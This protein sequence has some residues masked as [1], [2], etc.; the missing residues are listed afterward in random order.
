MNLTDGASFLAGVSPH[1]IRQMASPTS[2]GFSRRR[3]ERSS[4]C[5]DRAQGALW[6]HETRHLGREANH[7]KFCRYSRHSWHHPLYLH[8]HGG[9][10]RVRADSYARSRCCANSRWSGFPEPYLQ[11]L[12]RGEASPRNQRS[13]CAD[14]AWHEACN[15][16]SRI[17]R[18]DHRN[19]VGLFSLGATSGSRFGEFARTFHQDEVAAS[20][21]QYLMRGYANVADFPSLS[22]SV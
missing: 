6:C 16:G 9:R 18:V 5:V 3:V 10:R 2:V 19:V 17:R 1:Y 12:S 8:L 15:F 21:T 20:D 7:G 22:V 13:T 14:E 4:D 11:H